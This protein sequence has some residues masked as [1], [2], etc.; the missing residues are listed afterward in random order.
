MYS[1]LDSTNTNPHSPKNGLF[2]AGYN[3]PTTKAWRKDFTTEVSSTCVQ[4]SKKDP[5]VLDWE[6]ILMPMDQ[7]KWLERI[8]GY[9]PD[10]NFKKTIEG[11]LP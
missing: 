2:T 6:Q 10:G 7:V 8:T 4:V 3:S 11:S 1:F 9:L 5:W